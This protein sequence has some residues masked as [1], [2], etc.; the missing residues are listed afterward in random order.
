MEER[1]YDKAEE[2]YDIQFRE[3][4]E[5]SLKRFLDDVFVIWNNKYGD[6]AILH[7]LLNSLHPSITYTFERDKN[8]LPFLD[9]LITRKD[10]TIITDIYYKATDTK[11]YLHFYSHHPRTTRI[12]VP[13]NLARRICTIVS[14][15][16]LRS[17]RLSEL[18]STLINRKYPI[19]VINTGI[20][21]ARE[22]DINVLRTPKNKETNNII[23][24]VNTYNPYNPNIFGIIHN[25]KAALQSNTRLKEAFQ[26]TRIINSRRQPPNLKT[27]LSKAKFVTNTPSCCLV[28]DCGQKR[29]KCCQDILRGETYQFPDGRSFRIKDNFNCNSTNVIYILSC[30]GQNCREFYIG[31]TG[32]TIRNRCRV[33]RQQIKDPSIMNLKV[34]HHINQC[35]SNIEKKFTIMPIFKLRAQCSKIERVQKEA[36]FIS[37]YNPGLNI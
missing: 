4:L 30:N 14:D 17:I 27:L 1:L 26:D 5:N 23:P 36:Q 18:K 16:N 22:I 3:Y 37:K 15:E 19:T 9:I 35:A 12:N 13:Y 8:K 6:V 21:K 33:H 34:S 10:S 32:D 11:Q 28:N 2:S 25:S 7:D 31:Q 29:C 20:D 24:F